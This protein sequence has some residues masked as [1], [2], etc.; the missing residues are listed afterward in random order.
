M[1]KHALDP[2][3]LLGDRLQT[4]SRAELTALAEALCRILAERGNI[5][6][7]SARTTSA[8]LPT[9]RSVSARPPARTRRTGRPRSWNSWRPGLLERHARRLGRCVFDR[10]AAVC[11]RVG[12]PPAVLPGRPAAQP[13]DQAAALRRRMNG[14][15][16]PGAQGRPRPH[17]DHRTRHAVQT[18][19]PL[20]RA[21]GAVRRAR[22]VRR[23]AA[24]QRADRAGD[25]P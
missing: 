7:A 25:V 12:R 1:D 2:A 8:V 22:A 3:C 14:E 19:R 11:G 9:A 13:E 18:G 21:G 16:L 15:P 23:Q 24:P 6:A 10:P 5:T 20:R 4:L 17:G